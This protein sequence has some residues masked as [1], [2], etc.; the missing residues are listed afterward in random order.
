M[1]RSLAIQ[2]EVVAGGR[3]WFRVVRRTVSNWRTSFSSEE[4]RC[5][6]VVLTA[7]SEEGRQALLAEWTNLE[8][9]LS[10]VTSTATSVARLGWVRRVGPACKPDSPA[11]PVP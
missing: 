10:K 5:S 9:H 2:R 3:K 11:V 6:I 1:V 8:A 4:A 7:W